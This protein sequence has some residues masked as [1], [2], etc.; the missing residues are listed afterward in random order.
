ML[1][2]NLC[3]LEPKAEICESQ[4]YA[5]GLWVWKGEKGELRFGDAEFVVLGDSVGMDRLE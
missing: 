3:C 4:V 2:I 1:K 5:A